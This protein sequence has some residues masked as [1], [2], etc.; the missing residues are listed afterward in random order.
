MNFNKFLLI[1]IILVF[2]FLV[3]PKGFAFA[4]TYY[5]KNGGNDNADG[6]SDANAWATIIHA[7]AIVISGD[8]IFL[9]KGDIF[10]EQLTAIS[11]VIYDSYGTGNLPITN[12]IYVGGKTNVTIRNIK[13]VLTAG[14][15]GHGVQNSQ[16]V[17]IE[18]CELD[19]TLNPNM[20][21]T[22]FGEES[23]WC[24][25]IIFRNNKIYG[26]GGSIGFQNYTRNSFILNNE[27]YNSNGEEN[28]IQK[29]SSRLASRKSFVL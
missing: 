27:V 26:D 6:L 7:N 28:I 10:F 24:D 22:T 3:L 18:N 4:A 8:T 29:I 5:V 11:G 14:G 25:N 21:L 23:N 9:K 12:R 1:S 15:W 2:L 19:G 16:N 20:C 17:I 13:G